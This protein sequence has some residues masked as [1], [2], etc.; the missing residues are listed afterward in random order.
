M[1]NRHPFFL[2]Y[3]LNCSKQDILFNIQSHYNY[4]KCKKIFQTSTFNISV[5]KSKEEIIKELLKK[6]TYYNYIESKL[7]KDVYNFPI[8]IG[9]YGKTKS[10]KST[11]INKILGEKKSFEHPTEPTPKT[12]H[13]EHSNMPLVF[14]DT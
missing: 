11:F 14:F 4:N 12:L 8:N 7:Y 10:G 3:S 6:H 5:V 13:F 9:V 2:F 1:S